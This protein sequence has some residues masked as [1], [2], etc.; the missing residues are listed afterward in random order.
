MENDREEMK[1]NQQAVKSSQLQ[2]HLPPFKVNYQLRT[3]AN[4]LWEALR[5]AVVVLVAIELASQSSGHSLK[6]QKETKASM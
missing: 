1:F 2:E 5:R 4:F 6:K 3:A